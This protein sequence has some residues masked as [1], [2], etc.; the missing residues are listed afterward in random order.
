M[1]TETVD[2]RIVEAKF[3]S[4]EFEKGVDRTVKKLDEL[5][6]NLQLKDTGKS[7][8]ELA[9]KTQ[10]A[11]DNAS[12]SLEKLSDRFTSFTGMIKQKLLSGIADE[13]VGVFFKIKNSFESLVSSLSTAQISH[14]LDRYTEILTSVRTLT[15]AGVEEGSAYQAIER[16]GEYADQTSYSL[17]DLVSTMS[18]FKTAGA[19]LTTAQR[20]VEGLSN[21]A[22]SMG[23]NAQQASRAYLNMQ[24]AY[25]KGAML[26][27]DWISFESLPMVGEKFNQAIIDAAV[28]V[29]T[30][31][32]TTK[33]VYQTVKNIDKQVKTS[34]ADAKGITAQNMGTKLSSRWFNKAV[35]EEVFGN[36]YYFEDISRRQLKVYQDKEEELKE[37]LRKGEITK[38]EYDKQFN[39][40]FE[41]RNEE[42]LQDYIKTLDSQFVAGKEK[43][44]ELKQKL[45]DKTITQEE[46]NK[47]MKETVHDQKSYNDAIEEWKKKNFAT[48]FQYESFTAGQEARSFT[49]V[50]N[51]LK[52]A[53]SRGWAQSFE[54]LF[55]KLDEAKEFFTSLT[56]GG[57]ADAIYAI[58]EFRNAV[59]KLWHGEEGDENS[60]YGMLM[61]ALNN[62]KEIIDQIL[63]QFTIFGGSE[64]DLDKAAENM[65]AK[66][67]TLTRRFK[68]F[69]VALKD[70][71]NEDVGDGVK[72]YE[73]IGEVFRTLSQIIS[74]ALTAIDVA[75]NGTKTE[76]GEKRY[77]GLLGILSSFKPILSSVWGAI[78][79]VLE[80]IQALFNPSVDD[81]GKTTNAAYKGVLDGLTNV[82][83]I[84]E[85]ITPVLT[86]VIDVIG[87]VAA[88]FVGMS[89]DTIT[90]NIQFF[91]DAFGF[92]MELI[93]GTSS[94]KE[95]GIGVIEGITN[96][97]NSLGE[98]CKEVLSSVKE[99]FES[100]FNDI[101]KL[102]GIGDDN[103]DTNIFSG[104]Q[105]WFDTNEFIQ[106]VKAWVDQAVKDVS[107]FIADMPN[108]IA[109][110]GIT[111]GDFFKPLFYYKTSVANTGTVWVKK[112]IL[113]W[114]EGVF[115]TIKEFFNDI[116]EGIK[117]L[118]ISIGDFFKPLFYY[119]TS[120]ANTGTV[121]VK[122]PITLWIESI[123][124]KVKD[125][126]L[127]VA[128]NF[129]K[130]A[131]DFF[132]FIKSIFYYKTSVANTGKTT[133]VKKPFTIWIESVFNTV[134]T[135][136][137]EFIKNIPTYIG[138]GVNF[139]ADIIRSILGLDNN[140]NASNA[141]SAG[142]NLS[143][144]LDYI[145]DI[146]RN[147]VNGIISIFTGDTDWTNN[148]NWLAIKVADGITWIKD[149][150]SEAWEKT[151]EFIIKLPENISKLFEGNTKASGQGSSIWE[152]ITGFAS[153]VGV[154]ISEIPNTLLNA[155]KAAETT[156][157]GLWDSIIKWIAG[158]DSS[159][160]LKGKYKDIY[161]DFMKSP[162]SLIP[163]AQEDVKNQ[164]LKDQWR[165]DNP[166]AANIEDFFKNLIKYIG[167]KILAIPGDIES[168][169]KNIGTIVTAISDVLTNNVDPLKEDDPVYTIATGAF[170]SI[171]D[172]FITNKDKLIGIIK[173]GWDKAITIGSIIGEVLFGDGAP[174]YDQKE[175]DRL[176]SIAGYGDSLAKAYKESS[177]DYGIYNGVASFFDNIKNWVLEQARNLPKNIANAWTGIVNFAGE[178]GPKILEG[179]NSA[180]EWAKKGFE[181]A[182]SWLRN[183]DNMTKDGKPLS[184]KDAL[185]NYFDDP[186]RENFKPLWESIKTVGATIRDFL[187]ETSPS[188][189]SAA[190]SQIAER[191]P[192]ILGGLFS[193]G[194]FGNKEENKKDIE[195][196]ILENYIPYGQYI[197][198]YY[199]NLG[200]Q[201]E[202]AIKNAE[203]AAIGYSNRIAK[204]AEKYG[205]SI[206]E[207]YKRLSNENN[208]DHDLFDLVLGHANADEEVTAGK[209][210]S[211]EEALEFEQKKAEYEKKINEARK[212]LTESDEHSEDYAKAQEDI[213]KY[214]ELLDNLLHPK[215]EI[216]KAAEEKKSQ[217]L[218]ETAE[219]LVTSFGGLIT[220][221]TNTLGDT[222]VTKTIIFVGLAILLLDELKE[223]FS[224]TDELETIKGIAISGVMAGVVALFGLITYLS[225]T[226]PAKLDKVIEILDILK[227]IAIAIA[228]IVGFWK[229]SDIIDNVKE[230]FTGGDDLGKVTAKDKDSGIL[231][232]ATNLTGFVEELSSTLLTPLKIGGI[233]DVVTEGVQSL[234]TTISSGFSTIGQGID[235]FLEYLQPTIS[236]IESIG[237]KLQPAIDN[238][239]K[240]GELLNTF[241]TLMCS[242]E[243][244]RLLTQI[245][246]EQGKYTTELKYEELEPLISNNLN[247]IYTMTLVINEL[248]HALDSLSKVDDPS[249]RLEEASKLFSPGKDGKTSNF[250]ELYKNLLRSILYI[251]Q[252]EDDVNVETAGRLADL[253]NVGSAT[254]FM[255][256]ALSIFSVSVNEISADGIDK[257]NELFT[258][259]NKL[260]EIIGSNTLTGHETTTLQKFVLGDTSLAAFGRVLNSFSTSM[261]GVFRSLKQ[262]KGIIAD[263][264]GIIDESELNAFSSTIDM[265]VKY[266]GNMMALDSWAFDKL[267]GDKVDDLKKSFPGL[268]TAIAEGLT[269]MNNFEGFESINFTAINDA[270]SAVTNIGNVAGIS[271]LTSL[272]SK[273]D[274]ILKVMFG[275][276]G[277]SGLFGK[278]KEYG[279]GWD[280]SAFG[281]VADFIDMI[282][283]FADSINY[284]N[285]VDDTGAYRYEQALA[286]IAEVMTTIIDKDNPN[287][288]IPGW[289]SIN[290][291]TITPVIDM[292]EADQSLLSR[293]EA[294]SG[295][296]P[297]ITMSLAEGIDIATRADFEGWFNNLSSKIE[298]MDGHLSN[299]R[300]VI[301]GSE[302]AHTIYPDLSA[303]AAREEM[304]YLRTNGKG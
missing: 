207:V 167:D 255:A 50:I 126:A 195:Q 163:K 226:D 224:L 99:F 20:M 122:K 76:K 106:K 297:T 269:A 179:L 265:V 213:K 275:E 228:V 190:V 8:T 185:D 115:D 144:I 135:A 214:N 38:E 164:L 188:F 198:D 254:R 18:K 181:G 29:G 256:D 90:M 53:I 247:A 258:L 96:D 201:R 7:I 141:T 69:T 68:D 57:I 300:F 85:T 4:S 225:A 83:T 260:A 257:L 87:D 48:R 27:S 196:N 246:I 24:Q 86:K 268:A 82:K 242:G 17:E 59:L 166:V 249:K 62:I 235:S 95:N 212:K 118:G 23:V 221:V 64:E 145:K 227:H 33:G 104:I 175:F 56:E 230:L 160:E 292:S 261:I 293:I 284:F 73:R 132:D 1:A 98:T 186:E 240:I 281:G 157:S 168:A 298:T 232:L 216:T 146:G 234:F 243:W 189:I 129:K 139:L 15:A 34:G 239:P 236:K 54:Y 286:N 65:S 84:A 75:L 138:T 16:L 263:A 119:K 131:I 147:I 180:L 9:S 159:S 203:D 149:K 150:A 3:D 296:A 28:R 12:K 66:I 267:T 60:G 25:S 5:K 173:D 200:L 71:L 143:G 197:N 30:L 80:P 303:E 237:P 194:L 92:L 108:R 231:A 172:W 264:D 130:Y 36:T 251:C 78:K 109:Q 67:M 35:M 136:L 229:G 51:T 170:E 165:E 208:K 127:D 271:Q 134:K 32:E 49:D 210:D 113:K 121:W 191:V 124:K 182:T 274:E 211:L 52:D 280:R 291:P 133:W 72:R 278:L 74:G 77:I 279:T 162:E 140:G 219:G 102:L 128:T 283:Q 248:N 290:H 31:K 245:N 107:E 176:Y 39:E 19:S 272:S 81:N 206:N 40:F 151:K 142:I 37:Q 223:M 252:V 125:F 178:V 42:R 26:Q 169:F 112:P 289:D 43:E 184:I 301:N 205:I 204:I 155:W 21:A 295:L 233:M 294:L 199:T 259:I 250:I 152:S 10:E 238:I 244:Q 276:D 13:I 91:S 120:V 266:A 137:V 2:T 70:W 46:Y 14:G 79:K 154:W 93:F 114:F 105:N 116:P 103:P 94:Q 123:V 89:M 88:F 101:K 215:K 270:I 287:W 253:S 161:D 218:V 209:L 45:K 177:K 153:Q 285:E 174:V 171:R 158:G 217:S 220:S 61:T 299:M 273:V 192:T 282:N 288:Q 6:K 187:V 304:M 277:Q 262:V 202:E 183:P 111:I 302:I 22:A 44:K 110:L 148:K 55:G 117:K 97:I 47:A 241:Y 156:V 63:G 193:G 58:G 222:E 11:T 100:L 41:K